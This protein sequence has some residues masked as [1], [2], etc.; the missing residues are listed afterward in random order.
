MDLLKFSVKAVFNMV[1]ILRLVVASM[2]QSFCKVGKWH[3]FFI[4]F[5]YLKAFPNRF[6]LGILR[7]LKWFLLAC[8][9]MLTAKLLSNLYSQ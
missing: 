1:A 7:F 3:E 5:T 6:A 4:I 9:C 8:L 2:M